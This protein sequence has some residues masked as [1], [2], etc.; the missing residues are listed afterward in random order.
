MLNL[1]KDEKIT[2]LLKIEKDEQSKYLVFA[3]KEGLIKRTDIVEFDS[4]RNNGKKA[5][6]LRDD[7]KCFLLAAY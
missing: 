2:S 6:T 5:I 3:T 4:I 1:D 7:E